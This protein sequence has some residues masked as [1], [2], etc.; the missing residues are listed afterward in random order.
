M[1]SNCSHLSGWSERVMI[2]DINWII[3][4]P[5][6]VVEGIKSWLKRLSY[7][8]KIWQV[9]RTIFSWHLMSCD[10]HGT[11]ILWLLLGKNT[12]KEG[13]LREGASTLSCFHI[14]REI[15]PSVTFMMS[16]SLIFIMK[17]IRYWWRISISML[18]KL[19]WFPI[20]IQKYSGKIMLN[21]HSKVTNVQIW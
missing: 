14:I 20:F 8:P 1:S 19:S 21:D 12:D 13:T 4:P 10:L 15:V 11:I 5:A 6:S 7:E 9:H 2:V 16:Y 18:C 3:F 17:L